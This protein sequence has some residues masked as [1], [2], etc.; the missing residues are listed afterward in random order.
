MRVERGG[1]RVEKEVGAERR[2]LVRV[3]VGVE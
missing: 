2:G 3:R 1:A